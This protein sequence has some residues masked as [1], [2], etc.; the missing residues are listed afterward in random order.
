MAFK[1]LFHKVK[2]DHSNTTSS[3]LNML[4]AYLKLTWNCSQKITSRFVPIRR[5]IYIYASCIEKGKHKWIQLKQCHWTKHR[6]IHGIGNTTI[7]QSKATLLLSLKIKS[8]K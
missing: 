4:L 8:K 2:I 1:R 7:L 6:F 3:D 5:I